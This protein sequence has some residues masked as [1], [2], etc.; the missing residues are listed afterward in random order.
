MRTQSIQ[1]YQ[2]ESSNSIT[3]LHSKSNIMRRI[4]YLKINKFTYC[5]ITLMKR[6]T[7]A[8]PLVPVHLIHGYIYTGLTAFIPAYGFLHSCI[9]LL[10]PLSESFSDYILV[11]Q[12]LVIM[13]KPFQMIHKLEGY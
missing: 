7:N 3:H 12:N 8:Y 9:V 13:R 2:N 1:K 4:V 5:T 10:L 11:L 6:L